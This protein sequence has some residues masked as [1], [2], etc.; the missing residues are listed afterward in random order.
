MYTQLFMS[1]DICESFRELEGLIF[2]CVLYMDELKEHVEQIQEDLLTHEPP[3]SPI[4]SPSP[5][6]GRETLTQPQVAP[7]TTRIVCPLSKYK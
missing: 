6:E 3:P 7:N 5:S 4:C 1:L 2:D